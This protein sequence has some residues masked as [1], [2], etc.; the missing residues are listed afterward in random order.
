MSFSN[1]VLVTIFYVF[2]HEEHLLYYWKRKKD[3]TCEDLEHAKC[4][5]IFENQS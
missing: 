4:V 2:L 3:K 1:I 5:R